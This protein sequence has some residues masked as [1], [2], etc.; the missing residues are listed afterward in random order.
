MI[1]YRCTR[2][3]LEGLVEAAVPG[4]LARAAA[5][6]AAFEAAGTYE[7]SASIWSEVKAVYMRLQ[8]EAKCVYCERKLEGEERGKSEHDVEHFR[9]KSRV[10]AWK[11]SASL[12]AQGVAVKAPGARAPGYH[13]LPYHLFNYSAACKPCNSALK[14]DHF[15][16]AGSYDFASNDPKAL[17]REKP[18]LV[19]PL[20]DFDADPETLIRFHGVSPQPVKRSG[21][22]RHR[23]LT[24]I[25]FFELDDPIRRKNLVRERA[26][27]IIA[28]FP[29]LE[30]LAGNGP[31]QATARKI[32]TGFTAPRSAHANCARCFRDLHARDRPEALAV[33][34]R[35]ADFIE[36][37]S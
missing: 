14:S 28:L 27:V 20:G 26:A 9:P 13:R 3:G 1:G 23:A 32:V 17:K 19:Y 7:E 21:H 33:F 12:L 24:T 5:R 31:G 8:G 36:T 37:S 18:L 34:D 29:Q 16:I 10:R 35:A 30:V 15:P 4:W 6:T 2:A 25:E 22:A 11:G